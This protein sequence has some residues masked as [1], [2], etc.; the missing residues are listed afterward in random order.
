[1]EK[2]LRLAL[3]AAIVALA[4]AATATARRPV[5]THGVS[6]IGPVTLVGGH[7]LGDTKPHTEACL[8]VSPTSPV[9]KQ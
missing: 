4:V 9:E 7:L 8:P 5:C 3:V 2:L 6:S 1:M